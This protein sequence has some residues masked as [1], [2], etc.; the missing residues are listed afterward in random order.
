MSVRPLRVSLQ[1]HH[2]FRIVRRISAFSR[3]QVH[4]SVDPSRVKPSLQY[5][6]VTE[7]VERGSA[8]KDGES[9]PEVE[10]EAPIDAVRE[11]A[12]S[13]LRAG[14]CIGVPPAGG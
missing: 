7:G 4:I 13:L 2:A 8:R 12:T 6:F 1:V 9:Q 5:T 3:V 11:D 10:L 14:V